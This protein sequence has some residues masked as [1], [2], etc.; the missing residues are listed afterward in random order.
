MGL[1][2]GPLK[3]DSTLFPAAITCISACLPVASGAL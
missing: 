1:E 2:A 3:R